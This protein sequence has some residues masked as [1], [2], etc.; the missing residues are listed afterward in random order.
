MQ[1]MC[2]TVSLSSSGMQQIL[3]T[4]ILERSMQ[5]NI[6]CYITVLSHFRYVSREKNINVGSPSSFLD[7][8][9]IPIA[10]QC[11]YL[12]PTISNKDSDLDSKHQ[13]KKM[14][15]TANLLLR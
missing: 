13:R 11:R 2:L 4:K 12:V 6:N 15:A 8:S 10:E 9:K 7:Q 5:R 14:Y 3:Y 1:M